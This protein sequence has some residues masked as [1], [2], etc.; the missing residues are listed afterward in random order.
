MKR[1]LLLFFLLSLGVWGQ[2]VLVFDQDL[3]LPLEGVRITG[4]NIQAVT[5]SNGRAL[6]NLPPGRH[7]LSFT[8]PGY[9]RHRETVA[10]SQGTITVK[11]RIAGVLEGE[12]LVVERAAPL[13]ND[14]QTGVSVAIDQEQMK[15]TAQIG[16][17]ED[18]MSSIKTLP[19]V[20]YVGSW[21][22]APSIRG[23]DPFETTLY[24]D[25]FE[26]LYPYHWG[27]S[28]SIFN[29]NM[30]SSAK[31]S[32]GL[33]SARY[34]RVL[35]GLVEINTKTADSGD[36]RIEGAITTTGIDVYLEAPISETMGAILGGKL[37]WMEVS[38]ALAGEAGFFNRVPY[39]YDSFGK[40]A[41]N[42][43]DQVKISLTGFLG[44][45]GV[46]TKNNSTEGFPVTTGQFDW[47][48]LTFFT[49]GGIRWLATQN[50]QV[51]LTGGFSHH[52]SVPEV[53]T[54]SSGFKAYSPEFLAKYDGSPKD[55]D[56]LV[57]GLIDSEVGYSLDGTYF[58]FTATDRDDNVQLRL[59]NVLVL[60]PGHNLIFGGEASFRQNS[61][62]TDLDGY[63]D[64]EQAGVDRYVP[65]TINT[66]TDRNKILNSSA[67]LLYEWGTSKDFFSGEIG[68]RGDHTYLW[69]SDLSLQTYPVANPR[70]RFLFQ[71]ILNEGSIKNLGLTLG[72]GVFSK[73]PFF[74]E[75]VEKSFGL[76]DFE[77]G[78][79][80]N[81]MALAGIELNLFG[82]WKFTLEGY[83][84]NYFQ[85]TYL[86]TVPETNPVK[87]VVHQ[88]GQGWVAG[89]DVLIRNRRGA[90]STG[91][92]RIALLL[93]GCII[94]PGERMSGLSVANL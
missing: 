68:V 18:V 67:F 84:K 66:S 47:E 34:G 14:S 91:T 77:I 50:Y 31:L 86:T 27:G 90:I 54:T 55:A 94:H 79:D 7:R 21:N 10:H 30:V 75:Q 76:K 65:V 85:R 40:W 38:F 71:P 4:D 19:G 64:F 6:L 73:A 83:Y 58:N 69:S 57:N 89:M 81:W 49:T 2:E 59:D 22:A 35:S 44:L 62:T 53:V 26:V 13:K 39:I 45:D 43:T 25:G 28:F 29:P 61:S 92:S 52:E 93:H 78:P 17:V 8:L 1:N 46:G 33:V 48:N 80:R 5:D 42:P 37:T 82:G 88:D 72:G 3:D 63:R 70:V 32:A 36:L 56:G 60:D 12:E 41:W 74:T 23:G 24:M 16:I 9:E 11:L 51:S 20:G 87:I 15:S